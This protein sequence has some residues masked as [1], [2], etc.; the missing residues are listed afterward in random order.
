MFSKRET[1]QLDSLSTQMF[2]QRVTFETRIPTSSDLER[3]REG[4]GDKLSLF[5]QMLSAFVAGFGVGFVY[6]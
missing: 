5:I 4:L 1:L 2:L 6:K 3:V